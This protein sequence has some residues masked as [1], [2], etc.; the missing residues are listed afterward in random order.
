MK[1]VASGSKLAAAEQSIIGSLKLMNS[2]RGCEKD[3]IELNHR[4]SVAIVTD[5]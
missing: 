3:G 5:G 2:W 1:V 4:F